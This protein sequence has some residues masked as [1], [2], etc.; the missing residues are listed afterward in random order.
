MYKR[1][2]PLRGRGTV[3]A[4]EQMVRL[5]LDCLIDAHEVMIAC[6]VH[7]A[8]RSAGPAAA[9]LRQERLQDRRRR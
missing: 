3:S 9:T 4:I 6:T 1:L 5:A 2:V 7:P 8:L